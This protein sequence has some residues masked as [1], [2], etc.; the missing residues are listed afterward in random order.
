MV[1]MGW[2]VKEVELDRA[3]KGG[4]TVEEGEGLGILL[5]VQGSM[6]DMLFYSTDNIL[7]FAGSR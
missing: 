1:R 2:W 7:L 4:K 6:W 5:S 3:K